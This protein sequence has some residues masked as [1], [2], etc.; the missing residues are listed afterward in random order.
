M[1]CPSRCRFDRVIGLLLALI[2]AW[3]SFSAAPVLAAQTPDSDPQVTPLTGSLVFIPFIA[4]PETDLPAAPSWGSARPLTD[5]TIELDWNDN[6][7]NE[8]GFLIFC[9]GLASPVTI[10]ANVEATILSSLAASTTYSCR[11]ASYNQAGS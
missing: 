11:I 6:S 2:L 9:S 7:S 5:S 3:C 10:G 8:Q 1:S 4:R